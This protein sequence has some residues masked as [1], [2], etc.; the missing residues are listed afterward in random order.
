MQ[1]PKT[2]ACPCLMGLSLLDACVEAAKQKI[3]I[4]VTKTVVHETVPQSTII[5][6]YPKEKS[7]IKEQQIVYV[8]VSVTPPAQYAPDVL[9]KKMEDIKEI[10][11][12]HAIEI[13]MH[14]INTFFPALTIFAQDPLP[15]KP[16]EH[17]KVKAYVSKQDDAL[18]IMPNCI[19]HTLQDVTEL[20]DLHQIAYTC[21]HLPQKK[22]VI[23]K[24]QRPTAG[25]LV[26]KKNLKMVYLHC[27]P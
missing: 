1:K 12:V 26:T 18:Y 10:A 23:I 3:D 5:H 25:T 17:N 9:T 4:R 7:P 16:V 21:D 27:V 24:D 22:D 11:H 19:G 20:F 14:H 6:Q 15:G 8:S 13:E 2:L